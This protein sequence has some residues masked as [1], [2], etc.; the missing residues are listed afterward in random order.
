MAGYWTR[1]AQ[2]RLSRRRALAV[3]GGALAGSAL[4]AACGSDDGGGGEGS[5]GLIAKPVYIGP[6]KATRG[7]VLKDHFVAEPRGLDPI[8]AQAALNQN[9]EAVYST[10]IV[11]KPG[12]FEP[13]AY[14]MQGDLAQSWEISGDGLQITMKL[15]PGV[16]W[17]NLPPVNGRTF[18]TEDVKA[19]L[20]RYAAKGPLATLI[21]NQTSPEA[22][23]LSY[24]SPDSSSIVMK[25]KEPVA[26]MINWFASFGG[27]TAVVVLTPKETDG[28]FDIRQGMIGTGPFQLKQHT[29][30]VGFVL[31]RNPDYWDKDAA[32]VDEVNQPIISE[33]VTRLAQLK[34]GEI[35]YSTTTDVLRAEDVLSTK[36]DQPKIE[37]FES[38]MEVA[39]SVMT[40]G[41]QPVGNNKFQDER[42]RQAISMSM[43]RDLN[44][45]VRFNAD[46]FRREG[47][48]IR[49][50]WNSHL[51]ARDA[52]VKGGWFLDPKGKDFGPNAKFFKHDIAEA[53][54]L[55]AA[56]GFPNGFET[57]FHYPASPQFNR[58]TVVE[59]LFFFLQ[60]IGIKV[61]QN[62]QT[63]NTQ[64][65][66]PRNRDASGEY[67]GIGYHS[68]TGTVP[69]VL[70][71]ASALVAEHLPISGVT[72]HG[73]A[74]NGRGD[75][76]GD[77][78][79]I[80]IL[81][82]ARVERDINAQK[83]LV[84]DAQRYLGK[85]M[86]SLI[87]PGGATGFW[88]AWPAVQNFR[89]FSG[90]TPWERYQLWL[91]RTKAPFA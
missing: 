63:D 57:T 10:L 47:L 26:Y 89:V 69:S 45:D 6:D 32:L 5:Q 28:S 33:Y 19:A 67:E 22:P 8:T 44:I 36:R 55:L 80:A 18:D 50:A 11:E 48:P 66:I 24:S 46:T 20:D 75:K 51:A 2:G 74:V 79:L 31:K 76:S 91:D 72:F 27:F 43:D 60:E 85:A 59:P 34:A 1:V 84:L 25:L 23:L 16:K 30:S 56:A 86:H 81:A 62:P 53:K 83:K 87:E 71:A 68:V 90:V 7:G 9:A 64:V 41:W 73:Y 70:S 4:L 61:N 54:K 78:E 38:D 35:H 49:T 21:F 82:K 77:P 17:H 14:E 58:S 29:P 12:R 39:A 15:R 65:Y 42:V 88:A 3:S 13:S 52:F 40:F 37:L